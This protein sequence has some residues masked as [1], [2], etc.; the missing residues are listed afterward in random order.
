MVMIHSLHFS[1]RKYIFNVHIPLL[2]WFTGVRL[3]VS[4]FFNNYRCFGWWVS[5]PVVWIVVLGSPYER[6]CYIGLYIPRVPNHRAPWE[7]GAMWL[8]VTEPHKRSENDAARGLWF[9]QHPK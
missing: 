1:V 5:V 7:L 6:D 9:L 4:V 2:C 3:F 8:E